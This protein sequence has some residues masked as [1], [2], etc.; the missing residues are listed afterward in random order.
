MKPRPNTRAEYDSINSYL[1]LK[2]RVAAIPKGPNFSTTKDTF[3]MYD[4]PDR[5]SLL[6]SHHIQLNPQEVG[7]LVCVQLVPT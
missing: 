6:A 5:R 2:D 1:R 3:V 4:C 7:F